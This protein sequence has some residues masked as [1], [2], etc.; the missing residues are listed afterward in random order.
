MFM[1]NEI[2][3]VDS[4]THTL[5]IVKDALLQNGF[6]A[7]FSNRCEL[8]MQMAIKNRPDLILSEMALRD[9]DGLEF[10]RMVQKTTEICHV[11]FIFLTSRTLIMDKIAA[12]EA[13]AD[14][15]ITKPFNENELLARIK[16]VLRRSD[17]SR[18]SIMTKEDGI[19]GNL[20]DINL[21]DL[22]QLFDM[23]RKTA[24]IQVEGSGKEG[25]IY[26]DGGEVVHAVCGKLFGKES[27][28]DILTIHEGTFLIH[29]N[30]RSKIRTIHIA[31]TNLV[32]EAMHHFDENNITPPKIWNQSAGPS[33]LQKSHLS[34]GIKE[35][36]EEGIIEEYTKP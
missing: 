8:A 7:H 36:F 14:D 30:I 17:R 29:L 6:I 25:R 20:K 12:L 16:A 18:V 13:G 21:L 28:F 31:S 33:S 2:L 26:F 4:D 11:P 23:G 10:M 22:I 3:I 19:K 1:N 5:R 24:V 15:Y 27:L 9:M 35:L 32:M 34:E